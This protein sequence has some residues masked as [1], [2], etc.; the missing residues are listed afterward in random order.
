MKGKRCAQFSKHDVLHVTDV[1][2]TW[3]KMEHVLTSVKKLGN[4]LNNSH[5]AWEFPAGKKKDDRRNLSAAAN[6]ATRLRTR[7]FPMNLV[8]G[9]QI[10]RGWSFT[11]LFA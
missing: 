2:K 9:F 5:R 3:P 1:H 11:C 8:L 4:V 7:F 6:G 10:F